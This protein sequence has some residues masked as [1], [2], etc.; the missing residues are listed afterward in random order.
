MSG[1][2]TGE[3]SMSDEDPDQ[4]GSCHRQGTQVTDAPHMSW[5]LDVGD[6]RSW[7]RAQHAC[8]EECPLLRE[9][10]AQ[11]DRIYHRATPQA[12]IWA[13]IAYGDT[14]QVLDKPGLRR[15]AATQRR[16]STPVGIDD[17]AQIRRVQAS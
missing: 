8:L 5:D 14:G 13:G 3:G 12:V 6:L 7:M 1:T 11:R 16:R 4:L 2:E 10:I 9:C 15:R 17:P